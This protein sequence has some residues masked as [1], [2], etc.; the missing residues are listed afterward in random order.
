MDSVIPIPVTAQRY[1][2]TKNSRR[3]LLSSFSKVIWSGDPSGF[4]AVELVSLAFAAWFSVSDIFLVVLLQREEYASH[5]IQFKFYF[6]IV[7]PELC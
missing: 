1:T 7:F 6:R 2:P 3:N 4:L 5:K